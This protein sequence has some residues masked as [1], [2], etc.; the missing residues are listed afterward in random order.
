MYTLTT[1][2]FTNSTWESNIDYRK[3]TNI[4]CIYGSPQEMSSSILYDSFVFVVEMN[5]DTNLIEGIG[6][7]S[8]KPHLDK[9]YNIYKDGNYNR[10]VYKSK[11][12]LDRNTLWKYNRVLVKV[13]EYIVFSE[14]SHLKRGCGFTTITSKFLASKKD[15]KCKQ[16]ALH[17]IIRVIIEYFKREYSIIF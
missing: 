6:L 8:N 14:K 9:Y 11:Y 5:N 13:L 2:R 1:T 12:R 4:D 17:K 3:K 7:V 10:F 16:L 15:E